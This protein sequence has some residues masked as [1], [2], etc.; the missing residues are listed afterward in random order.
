MTIRREASSTRIQHKQPS[1][2]CSRRLPSR[3]DFILRLSSRVAPACIPRSPARDQSGGFANPLEHRSERDHALPDLADKAGN[4]TPLTVFDKVNDSS[5]TF[6]SLQDAQ[7][8]T[9]PESLRRYAASE[10][11]HA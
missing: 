6:S 7:E 4:A 8:E 3:R 1:Q 10:P 11:D 5:V 9:D 2:I